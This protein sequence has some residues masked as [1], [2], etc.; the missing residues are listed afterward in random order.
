MEVLLTEFVSGHV[1]P[2]DDDE[3]QTIDARYYCSDSCAKGDEAYRGW[4]GCHEL[5]KGSICQGCSDLI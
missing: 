2:I 5:L 4:S 3:G 1:V